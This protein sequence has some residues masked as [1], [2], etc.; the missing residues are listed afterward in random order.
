MLTIEGL[1]A[2]YG[3]ACIIDKLALEVRAGEAVSL[4]GRN[5]MGKTTLV[6]SILG[7]GSPAQRAGSIVWNGTPLEGFANH[8]RARR[9]IGLVPQGRHVFGSLTVEENLKT[10]ARGADG[11]DS[12][13][14]ERV[15]ELFPR[16]AQR[17]QNKARNLSGGEQQM[18]AIG[19]ALMTNPTL[20]IMDEPSEGLAPVVV[21]QMRDQLLRLKGADLSILLV[22]QNIGLAMALADRIYVLELGQ[23]VYE[24]APAEFESN[25]DL[26]RKF[27]GV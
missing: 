6:R 5:G 23:I 2:N 15:Y 4:L 25:P 1:T 12:W 11:S 10:T 19:R 26:Q 22:E 14:L 16:L 17:R 8:Q 3:A 7:F 27:L 21:A 20:L 18:V 13:T 24:G 9:G